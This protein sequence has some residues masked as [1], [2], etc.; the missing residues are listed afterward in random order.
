MNIRL[1]IAHIVGIANI[2][3]GLILVVLFATANPDSSIVGIICGVLGGLCMT[4]FGIKLTKIVEIE[5]NE[6]NK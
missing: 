1:T 4:L 3:V 2:I 5:V 6:E